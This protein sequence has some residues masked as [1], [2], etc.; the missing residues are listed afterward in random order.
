MNDIV[1][2]LLDAIEKEFDQQL[3]DSGKVKQAILKLKAKKATYADANAF[4]IELGEILSGALGNNIRAELLPDGK[5][6]YNIAERILNQT[7]NKNHELISEFAADV[8]TQLN[9]NAGLKMKG[10]KAELN[11]DRIDGIIN[12]I[13]SEDDFEKVEWLLD[14]PIKSFSQ[15]IV[16]DTIKQ[17]VEFHAKSGLKPKIVRKSTGHCCAWCDAVEGTY[18]YPDVPK[19]VYRRHRYC[20]CTV[21]YDPGDGK[22]TNVH[23]KKLSGSDED[24]QARIDQH[25]R[26]QR[27]SEKEKEERKALRQKELNDTKNIVNKELAGIMINDIEVRGVSEHLLKRMTD[28]GI[29][30]SELKDILNN[31]LK[32]NEVKLDDLGR[33]SFKVIGEK[34]TLAINP[35]NGIITTSHRTHTKLVKKLKGG[36]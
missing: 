17:N 27:Q 31:P 33:P 36:E 34:G 25:I 22:R 30:V 8:Q 15:S 28:R 1:P 20:R 2:E 13:S 19:D 35:D 24:K 26:M 32:I 18:E 4:A 16:D 29:D 14:E 7:M 5:M 10:Q 9:Y 6:H 21:E 3:F 11:Q 23:T 12:K